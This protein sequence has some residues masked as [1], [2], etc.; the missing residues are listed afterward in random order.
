M[1]TLVFVPSVFALFHWESK[2]SENP[3]EHTA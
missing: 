1:A 2:R 3:Q